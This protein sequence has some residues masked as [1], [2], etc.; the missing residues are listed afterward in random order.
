MVSVTLQLGFGFEES[1]PEQFAWLLLITTAVTTAVW[2][3]VTLVTPPEPRPVLVAFY[4]RVRPNAGGWKPVAAEAPD[5]VPQ[6]DGLFNLVN[7][8]SGVVMIY[9]FLFGAGKLI[10][11][12]PLT[13]FGFLAVGL[14]AGAVIYRGMGRRAWQLS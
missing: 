13:G 4:R 8:L 14:L 11:G 12:E 7:W 6:H 2:L 3:T 10:L 5:I 1:R 9:A